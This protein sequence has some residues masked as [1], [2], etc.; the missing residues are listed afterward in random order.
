M[1]IFRFMYM[2]V[3]LLAA[4]TSRAENSD[5]I[6]T[7]VYDGDTVKLRPISSSNSNDEFKLRLTGIDA[8]ERNQDFGLQSRRALIK[9]CQ[10]N[11]IFVTT[12]VV[13]K[14]KYN[15]S[16]GRLYCNHTD[17]SIYLAERGLA[18]NNARYSSDVNIY[19]ADLKARQQR[20][21]L[22]ADDNP[23]PP[24]DWRQMHPY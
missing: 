20:L 2:S 8:P 15:R 3:C 17:A 24:W 5:Y 23:I 7:Y 21:G 12:E 6:V 9:L 18:W 10:G 11:N 22:W 16:L 13:A 19:N 1:R 14:D 4:L